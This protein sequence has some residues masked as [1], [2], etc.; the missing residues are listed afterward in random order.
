M[1]ILQSLFTTFDFIFSFWPILLLNAIRGRRNLLRNMLITWS[2]WAVIRI[3]L[4]FNPEPLKASLFIQEPLSTILFF[5]CG[6][7]LVGLHYGWKIWQRGQLLQKTGK[8]T[9]AKDL[10]A[11]SPREFEDMAV[12]LFVAYGHDARRTGAVGDHG[13][14]V[15]V[16]T[17][18]GEKCVVQC[19]RWK[20][21]VGEP[22]VRDFYGVVLHEK[23]DKGIIISSG[24]F[25]RPAQ[26]W[27]RG[28][29]IA[30]YDGEK[31]V[32]L[33]RRAQAK[34]TPVPESAR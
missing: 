34:K 31:F 23:A 3:L 17:K 4:F 25:S 5:A 8:V 24:K 28:K 27:A 15:I 10:L 6:I 29:P 33:W 9:T 18:N 1:T 13:V 32:Q 21:Y 19:K 22:V 20:G 11:L 30:L 16:K 7:L 2:F 12:E 26:E 14:D